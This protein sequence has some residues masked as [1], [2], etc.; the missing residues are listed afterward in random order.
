MPLQLT[1]EGIGTFKSLLIGAEHGRYLIV[2]L[3]HVPD[4]VSKLYQKNHVI[5]RYLHAGKV[6]G[7]RSTLIGSIKEPV[8]LFVLSYPESIESHNTRKNERFDCLIPASIHMEGLPE[9]TGWKGFINDMSMGGCR[10][11][12]KVNDYPDLATLTMGETVTLSF[13]FIGEETWQALVMEL[14]SLTVDKKMVTMG[15]SIKEG[16][17][18]EPQR[19]AMAFIQEIVT[20]LQD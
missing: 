6:F 13:R 12:A 17:E 9:E 7:F 1:V 14:R 20:S 3:P 4:L 19:K 16:I 15:L 8:R 10:F 2:K 11:R 5:V 18:T